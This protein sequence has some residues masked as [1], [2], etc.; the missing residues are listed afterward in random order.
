MIYTPPTARSCRQQIPTERKGERMGTQV[1]LN[2]KALLTGAEA[3]E[4]YNRGYNSMKAWAK[5][6]GAF[7][8]YGRR[9]LFVREILDDYVKNVPADDGPDALKE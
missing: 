2:E 6:C 1:S 9:A 7:R 8:K 5:E 3:C 4:R